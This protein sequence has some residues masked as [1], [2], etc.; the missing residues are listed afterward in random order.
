MMDMMNRTPYFSRWFS[1]WNVFWSFN[2]N[3][4]EFSSPNIDFV[5]T[6]INQEL[7]HP[8]LMKIARDASKPLEDYSNKSLYT[9]CVSYYSGNCWE[10][11][12]LSHGEELSQD[13]VNRI[14]D[15]KESL[16]I[17]KPI[18]FTISLFHGF[19]THLSY[20]TDKWQIGDTIHFPF[21]LSKTMSWKVATFFAANNTN[22]TCQNYLLCRYDKPG[23]KHICLDI[24]KEDSDEYE[25]L[26]GFETFK[27]V[28]KIYHM[29]FLPYPS[30]RIYYVMDFVSSD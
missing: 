19:E 2:S 11:G 6:N 7:I 22:S 5:K 12:R 4:I 20:K 13:D 8:Q 15:L 9:T 10:N 23:S 16:K 24:K 30:M 25:F 27:L 26:S 3:G 1:S 18:P 21:F 28:E 14:N 29:S 17:V